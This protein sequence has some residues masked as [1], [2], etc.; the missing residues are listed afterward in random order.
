MKKSL[1]PLVCALSTLAFLLGACGTENSDTKGGNSSQTVSPSEGDSADDSLSEHDPTFENGVLTT[2]ELK[3]QIT[4]YKVIKASQKGNENGEK[5]VIAFWYKTT[6][7]SGAKVDPTDF[8][9]NFN[10]YQDNN[11][12]A[13][14]E[15]DVGAL[16][17]RPV[18]QQPDREHQEG[19]NRRERDCL[20][21]RRPRHSGGLGCVR[22]PG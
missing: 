17:R 16:P 10:A 9:F 2:P 22:G 18:P 13:E 1:I 8:I 20:R 7:L 19:Q 14:N 12:N 21:A 4:R 11:P 5:P 3:I 6:N 15:L